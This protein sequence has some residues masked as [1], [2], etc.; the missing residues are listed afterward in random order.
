MAALF[1]MSLP[2]PNTEWEAVSTSHAGA[3]PL[4]LEP[5]TSLTPPGV[6]WREM[7][8]GRRCRR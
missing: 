5:R 4:L 6:L 8:G 7:R 1:L 3:D 2:E